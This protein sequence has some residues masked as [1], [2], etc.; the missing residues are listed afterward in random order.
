MKTDD[1]ALQSRLAPLGRGFRGFLSRP[2]RLLVPGS[3]GGGGAESV[4]ESNLREVALITIPRHDPVNAFT[5]G[6]IIP[7]SGLSVEEFRKLL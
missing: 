5:V 7:D 1:F 4:Q 3:D 6:G 2:A